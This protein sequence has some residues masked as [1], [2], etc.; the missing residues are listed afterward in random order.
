MI[1]GHHQGSS[2]EEIAKEERRK[3]GG[4]CGRERIVLLCWTLLDE[5]QNVP[6]MPDLA[7]EH[8]T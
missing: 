1:A 3:A 4:K 5:L 6:S 7:W 2:E 8:T